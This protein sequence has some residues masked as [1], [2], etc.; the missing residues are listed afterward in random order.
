MKRSVRKMNRNKARSKK[1]F[2]KTN[3]ENLRKA[4]FTHDSYLIQKTIDRLQKKYF[5]LTGKK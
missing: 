4:I 2:L 1:N 5:K 3:Y